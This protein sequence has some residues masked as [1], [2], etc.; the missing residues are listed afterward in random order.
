MSDQGA[1]LLLLRHAHV[2][3]GPDGGRL[4][5]WL[6]LPLS[7][8]GQQ[9]IAAFEHAPPNHAPTA[10]YTSPLLRAVTTAHVLAR[11]WNLTPIYDDALREI[12]CGDFEGRLLR[13]IQHH[14]P[15]IWARNAAQNDNHFAW[16]GGET[17]QQFRDRIVA[18]LS[19]IAA[20]HPGQRIAIVTHTGVITQ[21]VA[22]LE[23][24]P[25]AAWEHRRARP[26]S[27]T[28]L[29]WRNDAPQDLLSFNVETWWQESPPPA[30]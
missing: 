4:C 24:R 2:D 1:R 16:P 3:T 21:A 27:A 7:P 8:R 6:D 22:V 13:D 9:Q 30:E 23:N 28:E 10:L 25:P 18:A 14:H 12:F 5:G 19:R 26:F 20:C 17:Y 29:L 15:E 11:R